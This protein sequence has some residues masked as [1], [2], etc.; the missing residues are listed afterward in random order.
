MMY[1]PLGCRNG[2]Q[3]CL[4]PKSEMTG[5]SGFPPVMTPGARHGGPRVAR[6]RKGGSGPRRPAAIT[7][8]QRSAPWTTCPKIH[9]KLIRTFV[10]VPVSTDPRVGDSKNN[11]PGV[12]TT[13]KPCIIPSKGPNLRP[14]V[15]TETQLQAE[16]STPAVTIHFVGGGKRQKRPSTEVTAA[17]WEGPGYS[18]R[19]GPACSTRWPGAWFLH[20]AFDISLP[21]AFLAAAAVLSIRRMPACGPPPMPL[22]LSSSDPAASHVRRETRER[23]PR[24]PH[25]SSR[26]RLPA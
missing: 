22:D 5:T 23:T 9:F 15:S 21:V 16:S 1:Y 24:R 3:N 4:P 14:F 10:T 20:P 12:R 8:R 19:R 17:P 13:N 2:L 25:G 7:S 6:R 26:G 18:V 11:N